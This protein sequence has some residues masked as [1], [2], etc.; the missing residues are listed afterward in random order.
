[1]L[2]LLAAWLVL[3]LAA[4]PAGASVVSSGG[5]EY[6]TKTFRPEPNAVKTLKVPCPSGTH[7]WGGGHY[8]SGGFAQ[9]LPRHSFPYDGGDSGSTPDDGWGVQTSVS[10]DVVANVHAVCARP[11]PRYEEAPV[12]ATALAKT[13]G[14]VD[15]DTDFEAVSG[16]TRGS[17]D[18]IETASGPGLGELEW[19]FS[20]DNYTDAPRTIKTY[21]VCAERRVIAGGENDQVLPRT[22]EGQTAGCADG[23]RI[24]GGGVGHVGAYLDIGLVASRPVGFGAG[25]AD[26]W[27]VYLDDF[28]N[29]ATY[30]F[31]V[32][33]TCVAP[34]R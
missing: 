13:G 17:R 6:V 27:Q 2:V 7:V 3:A 15:C 19:F 24:V 4:A 33:A 8:N 12:M 1:M 14:Q 30:G 32:W 16:G 29:S 20:L 31:T 10:E 5:F 21:A 34:L 25:G 26:G 23:R 28:S 22:Q 11:A 9:A 18:V